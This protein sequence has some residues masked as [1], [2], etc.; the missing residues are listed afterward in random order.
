MKLPPTNILLMHLRHPL[1]IPLLTIKRPQL[2]IP[3]LQSKPRPHLLQITLLPHLS[4]LIT[5]HSKKDKV[6]LVIKSSH[7]PTSK[8][9]V[10]RIQT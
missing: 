2:Q 7:L 3:Q 8:L 10:M 6:S 1:K 5:M 9:R 4:K